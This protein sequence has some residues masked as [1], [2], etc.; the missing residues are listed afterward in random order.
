VSALVDRHRQV[1]RRGKRTD[2]RKNWLT[3][4]R[5][6]VMHG[7]DSHKQALVNTNNIID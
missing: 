6:A 3:V 2:R 7:I 1:C 5:V 4:S